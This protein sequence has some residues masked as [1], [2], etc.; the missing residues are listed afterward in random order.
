MFTMIEFDL[1]SFIA[2]EIFSFH[3]DALGKRFS[4]E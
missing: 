3:P 2:L 1:P 4:H